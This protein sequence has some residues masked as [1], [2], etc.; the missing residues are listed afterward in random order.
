[1]LFCLLIASIANNISDIVVIEQKTVQQVGNWKYIMKIK[2]FF[3]F[4]YSFIEYDHNPVLYGMS[5]CLYVWT[6]YFEQT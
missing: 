6:I 5:L 2:L 3:I 4:V 1:M